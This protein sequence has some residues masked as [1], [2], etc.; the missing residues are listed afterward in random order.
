MNIK[1]K[2]TL[3]SKVFSLPLSAKTLTVYDIFKERRLFLLTALRSSDQV[4]QPALSQGNVEELLP[5]NYLH[6]LGNSFSVSK[7]HYFSWVLSY[8]GF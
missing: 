7:F 6:F 5:L 3:L 8:N 1:Y 2:E 4:G